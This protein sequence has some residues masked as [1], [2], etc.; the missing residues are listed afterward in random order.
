[1][2][3]SLQGG[4][5]KQAPEAA[6]ARAVFNLADNV[7]HRGI[8]A[9]SDVISK[10][11]LT[12]IE[13]ADIIELLRDA[14]LVW[15]SSGQGSGRNRAVVAI[16]NAM[17]SHL[18]KDNLSRPKRMF[19]QIVGDSD[20]SRHEIKEVKDITKKIADDNASVIYEYNLRLFFN[21]SENRNKAG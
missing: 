9:V 2:N 6:R 7:F 15:I 1:M 8:R 12:S 18:M 4:M 19:V 3:A 11:G 13:F 20:I 5:T 14:G 10:A 21:R 16:N 17:S